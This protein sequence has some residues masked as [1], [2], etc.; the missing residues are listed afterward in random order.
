MTRPGYLRLAAGVF[1]VVAVAGAIR[2]MMEGPETID[3]T[4]HHLVHAGLMLLSILSALLLARARR[5]AERRTEAPGWLVPAVLAPLAA[6]VLMVPTFYP[7][8][9]N[10]PA[11]HALSHLA[12]VVVA[13]V[14]AWCGERYRRGIGIATSLLLEVMAVAAA[15]GWGVSVP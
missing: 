10:H 5:D 8:L 11:V 14:T 7:Y 15:F 2:S 13:F 3:V 9:E 6:M 12:L 4:E 1:G